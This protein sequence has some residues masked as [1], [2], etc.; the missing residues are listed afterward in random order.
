MRKGR[1]KGKYP[2]ELDSDGDEIPD[3]VSS[4]GAEEVEEEVEEDEEREELERKKKVME[5][6]L[7]ELSVSLQKKKE[8]NKQEKHVKRDVKDV[9]REDKDVTREIDSSQSLAK[10]AR[11]QEVASPP[12]KSQSKGEEVEFLQQS[13]P[14]S[15]STICRN[16]RSNIR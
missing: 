14:T 4:S 5:A 10:K 13:W 12:A 9:T 2:K 15:W 8:S 6:L 16:K 1:K 7:A 11:L 3:F